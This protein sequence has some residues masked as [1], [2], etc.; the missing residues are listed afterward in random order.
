MDFRTLYIDILKKI[1]IICIFSVSLFHAEVLK[2]KD[3][4]MDSCLDFINFV[5]TLH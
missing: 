5:I 1:I 3:G 2:L 4:V